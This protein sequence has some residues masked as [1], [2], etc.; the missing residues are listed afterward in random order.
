MHT[1][2][3]YLIPCPH[4]VPPS[5]SF[6]EESRRRK[7]EKKKKR[8]KEKKKDRD[9]YNTNTKE[10]YLLAIE[11]ISLRNM[12]ATNLSPYHSHKTYRNHECKSQILVLPTCCIPITWPV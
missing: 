4:P 3:S 2:L 5:F 1:F 9:T 8:K 12:N 6:E 11:Y 10:Q 7:K